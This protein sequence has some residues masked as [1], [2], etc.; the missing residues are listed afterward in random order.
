MISGVTLFVSKGKSV[1]F[2]QV[3]C[4]VNRDGKGCAA[5]HM[6]VGEANVSIHFDS[7]KAGLA[8]AKKY[9]VKVKHD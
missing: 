5:L 6:K 8:F 2:E 9:D 7:Q 3:Y 4:W 1:E